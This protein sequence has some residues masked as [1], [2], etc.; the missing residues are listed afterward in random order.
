MS[1]ALNIGVTALS[2][3][4]GGVKGKYHGQASSE[5]KVE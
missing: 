3:L 2:P 5:E 1:K 4:A